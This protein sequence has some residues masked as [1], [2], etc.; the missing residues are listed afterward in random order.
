MGAISDFMEADHAHLDKLWN[1]FL[2][3]KEDPIRAT[4]LFNKFREHLLLHLKLEDTL[5]F[6]RLDQYLGMEDSFGPTEQARRD[7]AAIVRLLSFIEEAG[8]ENDME[9]INIAGDHL[10]KALLKHREREREIHYPV[11]DSFVGDAEWSQMLAKIYG[12]NLIEI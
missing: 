11:S 1:D 8:L 3:E 5:L 12:N 2:R 6:P 7:H 4:K 9:R 10:N